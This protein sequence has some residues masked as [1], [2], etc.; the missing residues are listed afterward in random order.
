M[1]NNIDQIKSDGAIAAGFMSFT[2]SNYIA[3]PGISSMLR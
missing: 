1:S 2:L 3:I